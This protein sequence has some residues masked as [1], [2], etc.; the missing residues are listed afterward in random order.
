MDYLKQY[1]KTLKFVF[2]A[3]I[4]FAPHFSQISE[5]SFRIHDLDL[6]IQ[7]ISPT[8]KSHT[9]VTSFYNRLVLS[10]ISNVFLILFSSVCDLRSC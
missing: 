3:A 1:T 6:N 10:N 2:V 7:N 5:H 8:F 9:K 4:F